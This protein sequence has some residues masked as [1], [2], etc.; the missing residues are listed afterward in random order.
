M[1]GRWQRGSFTIE[2]TF[3][4]P[5]ILIFMLQMLSIGIVFFQQSKTRSPYYKLEELDTVEHFYKVQKLKNF[6]EENLQNET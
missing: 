3:I 4:I 1:A 2:A 6:A 5:F